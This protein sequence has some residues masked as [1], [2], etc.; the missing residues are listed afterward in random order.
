MNVESILFGC[1]MGGMLFALILYVVFGQVTVRKLR[2]YPDTKNALGVEF[3]SGWDI[4][5]VAQALA[6]PRSWSKKLESSPLS[7]LYA[8][9]ESLRQNT[10]PFDRLLA[11]VFYWL[12]T[13]SG[14]TMIA[15]VVLDGLGI[16]R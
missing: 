14:M 5:N 9:S 2:K 10:T 11:A 8:N 15:L 13:A 3:A 6:I 7:A 16:I 12:F 1:S 4:L